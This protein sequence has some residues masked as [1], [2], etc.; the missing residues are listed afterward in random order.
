M[1]AACMTPRVQSSVPQR[2]RAERRGRKGKREGDKEEGIRKQEQEER[3]DREKSLTL[4][5]TGG[6]W[7]K[8][9]ILQKLSWKETHH[10]AVAMKAATGDV[11][12][13]RG[14]GC[15]PPTCRF[16]IKDSRSRESDTSKFIQL[17]CV[18]SAG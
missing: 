13:W 6:N 11:G 9:T 3:G 18:T 10:T 1:H 15:F 17:V 4:D 7:S 2:N 16:T 12:T 5:S 8:P 14:I